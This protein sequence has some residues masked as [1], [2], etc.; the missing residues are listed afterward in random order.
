MRLQSALLL[1]LAGALTTGCIRSTTTISLK[2]DGSGTIVQENAVGAQALAMIKSFAASGSKPGAA[3]AADLFTAEQAKKTAEAMGVTF[4]SG[5]PIKTGELEGY[6]ALYR[7][8]DITKIKINMQQGADAMVPA[9]AQKE[10][11]FGFGFSRGPASSVLTIQMPD[12]ST[13]GAFPGMPGAGGLDADQAQAAQALAM[14]KMMMQGMFL[15]VSIDVEGNIL[16]SNASHVQGSKITLLQV[17]FDKLL[18]D[19]GALKR[20]EAAKDIRGLVDIPGLKVASEPKLV[21]EFSR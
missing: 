1:A 12:Q 14:M 2:P 9:T 19:D 21:I 18:A 5:D 15:D 10:P 20:L 4:V 13:A 7:F 3:G 17:D 11:P 16:K 8:D 6:R